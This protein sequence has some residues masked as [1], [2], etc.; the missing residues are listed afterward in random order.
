M[1]HR[2]RQSDTGI[3]RIEYCAMGFL[4]LLVALDK[5]RLAAFDTEQK[6][7]GT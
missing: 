7:M 5:D 1:S 4:V 6:Y 2:C 3:P